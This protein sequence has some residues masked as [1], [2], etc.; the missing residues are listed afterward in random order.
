MIIDS[1]GKVF[2]AAM[3]AT[4]AAAESNLV[5]IQSVAPNVN[6]VQVG[7]NTTLTEQDAQTVSKLP[8]VSAISVSLSGHLDAKS[9]VVAGNQNWSTAVLG[10]FPDI[11]TVQ[12]ASMTQGSF[13]TSQD[14]SAGATTAVL[15]STVA[16]NLFP[17]GGVVGQQVRIA[18]PPSTPEGMHGGG[19]GNASTPTSAAVLFTVAGVMQP[20]GAGLLG[21]NPDDVIYVPFSTAQQRLLGKGTGT[22]GR[23]FVQVDQQQNVAG[24]VTAATKALEQNHRLAAGK[25]DDF[26]VG[27]FAAAANQAGAE[28]KSVRLVLGGITA[29]AL[30]IGGFGVANVMFASV[31]RRTREIGVRMAVGAERRHVLS[32]FVLEASVLSFLGGLIGIVL[33]YVLILVLL[34]MIPFLRSVGPLTS[35]LPGI[36][37]VVIAVVLAVAAGMIFGYLP[38]LRA[39]RLDPV[40]ALRQV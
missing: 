11:G 12:G 17:S 2:T 38:A 29:L 15:G 5:S 32:Q 19:G 21:N 9:Q 1:F 28:M 37:S 23:M 33:G 4:F 3:G 14:E 8:H 25:Q 16:K 20:Q 6:G 18:P 10:V 40:N 24:V 27:N 30:I 13:F 22:F 31:A 36:S 35:L 26:S 7:S 39:S 34:N